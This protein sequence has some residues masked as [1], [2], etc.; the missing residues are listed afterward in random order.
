[1]SMITPDCERYDIRNTADIFSIPIRESMLNSFVSRKTFMVHSQ[2][3]KKSVSK[4]TFCSLSM[5]VDNNNKHRCQQC[6]QKPE[7]FPQ[8]RITYTHSYKVPAEHPVFSPGR[9]LVGFPQEKLKWRIK[10]KKMRPFGR[11]G[12]LRVKR[13]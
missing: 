2:N 8:V 10:T 1:M 4:D 9:S 7:H 12:K 3:G 13:T 5:K 6:R 11:R